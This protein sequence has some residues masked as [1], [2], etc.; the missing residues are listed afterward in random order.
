MKPFFFSISHTLCLLTAQYQ[1]WARDYKA[2]STAIANRAEKL[3]E[4][5][6]LAERNLFLLGATAIEDRL[7]VSSSWMIALIYIFFESS[8]TCTPL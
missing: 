6:E 5:A 3:D 7:Q 8:F 2:A 1:Q 4:V